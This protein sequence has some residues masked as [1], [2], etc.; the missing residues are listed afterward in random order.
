MAVTINS[1]GTITGIA[2]GG[3]PDGVVDADTLADNAVTT[4]KINADAV[5]AAKVVDDVVNSEHLVDGG[6]DNAHLAAGVDAAKLTTGTIPMARLSGTLPALNGSALTN[7]PGGGKILQH[8]LTAGTHPQTYNNNIT[9]TTEFVSTTFTPTASNS[10]ILLQYSM[11]ISHE[12]TSDGYFY[13]AFYRGSTQIHVGL[14]GVGA[15]AMNDQLQQQESWYMMHIDSPATTSQLTYKVIAYYHV[16][17]TSSHW[18]I[19]A[20]RILIME[21]SPN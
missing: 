5:T 16:S 19:S 15:P 20:P 2:A 9:T 3:L 10:T 12:D 4:A 18:Y 13:G 7:L 11:A 17:P 1:N 14:I 21:L 8:K 6:V